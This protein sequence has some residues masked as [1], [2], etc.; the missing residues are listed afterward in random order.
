M[1]HSGFRLSLWMPVGVQPEI[2]VSEAQRALADFHGLS[3]VVPERFTFI[4]M[5]DLGSD[6]I[7]LAR[8][9]ELITRM[10]RLIR[11]QMDAGPYR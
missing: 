5:H 1:M 2:I 9:L 4:C 10:D 8:M 6:E 11:A 7:S 3:E